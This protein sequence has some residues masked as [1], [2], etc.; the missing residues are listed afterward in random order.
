MIKLMVDSAADIGKAEAD[1]LGIIMIPMMITFG[2]EEYYDGV[3]LTPDE[4][5]EKL[6]ESSVLPKTSQINAFRFEE[7][8]EKQLKNDDELIV[9]TISSKLSGTYLSAKEAAEKFAGRVHVIDSLNACIGERL[10]CEYALILI[11]QGYSANE[12][13]KL[14]EEKKEKIKVLALLGTLEY[15]KK[16]GRIS[17][18]VAFAGELISLKP[19]VGVVG[20]EVKLIGKALG[21]R[22][23][24]NLLSKLVTESNGIDFS[25]PY[26]TIW[27]GLDTGL[28]DKYIKDSASLWQ[29]NT[30]F[31][32]K[33]QLGATIG[34]HIG[35]GAVGVAFFEK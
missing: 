13:V 9:I 12:T 8:F 2:N 21:S 4:F 33:Y 28:L 24:N 25:M 14:L 3:D 19:V 16:G 22:K 29:G 23:G 17:G 30:E 32:P 26:G 35:P 7:A 18:A 34:T 15:L 6:I 27:S 5:Y 31:V 1:R 10:L 20:G 11:K